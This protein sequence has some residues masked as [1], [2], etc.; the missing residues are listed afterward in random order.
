M[1]VVLAIVAFLSVAQ[2]QPTLA[3]IQVH[4]NT[5]TSDEEIR[6]LAGITIGERVGEETAAEVRARLQAT[7]RFQ[8]VEVRQRFASIA[9]PSQIVLVIIVDEGAVRIERTGNPNDP[10]RIVRSRRLNLM[11]LPIIAREDGYGMIYGVRLARPDAAGRRSRV[12]AP[13]TWG[14]EKKAGI[15]IEKTIAR[16][17]IDWFT[18]GASFSR[19][20]NPF[21]HEDDDRTRVWIRGERAV[22]SALRIGG[23]ATWQRASFFAAEDRFV[24]VG[25]DV[26]YDTRVDPVLPRNAVYLRASLARLSLRNGITRAEIDARG[27]IGL[28]G[29][30]TV[31]IRVLQQAANASLPGYLKPLAGGMANLRGFAAGTMAG[32]NLFATSVELV[33]PLTSPLQVGKMGVSAFADAATAYDEGTSLSDRPLL[34]GVGGSVWFAAAFLRLN[35]AVGHG[36][37]S[38]TRVHVGATVSF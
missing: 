10:V 7:G 14:G 3:A 32:D 24:D 28:I 38:S 21:Y 31:A 13:L 9:D 36:I 35:A 11:F 30:S 37:G 33:L 23:T 8:N 19:R 34:R 4:G 16:G 17:P 20:T 15:E 25:A 12:S 1:C 29:Q 26:T 18:A 2:D 5:L 22:D 27:Y 6:H